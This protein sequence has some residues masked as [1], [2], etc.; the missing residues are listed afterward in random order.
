MGAGAQRGRL[1]AIDHIKAAAI[2]AV[3]FTHAGSTGWAPRPDNWDFFLSR[4]WTLFHVPSF[5]FASGFLY[6]RT[7][8]VDLAHVRSRLSRVLIPYLIA[9]AVAQLAG[10]TTA[11][12]LSDVA[13][14]L[15]TASSLGVYYYIF[16]IVVCIPLIWPLSRM[17]QRG[18]WAAWLACV[19]LTLAFELDASLRPT[20]SLLWSLRDPLEKFQLG[21]FLSGWAAAL[22]L[23]EIVRLYERHRRFAVLLAGAAVLLGLAL[24]VQIV[25]LPIGTFQRMIYTFGVIGTLAIATRA[26]PAGSVV[27]FLG[28]ASLAIY[29]YHRIFQLLA[30]PLCDGWQDPLRILGQ[31]AIGLGGASILVLA[32]RR[33]LGA[34]RARRLLGG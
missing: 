26:R 12:S 7:R 33:L 23:P 27:R 30:R 28:D 32:A 15:L 1:H 21:Y 6:A 16:I 29:L 18:V 19:A 10:V 25:D 31:V 5:L 13:Y 34:E 3:V 24:R 17:G 20:R 9:S 8:G 4:A 2:V 14:Q 22:A 11:Q